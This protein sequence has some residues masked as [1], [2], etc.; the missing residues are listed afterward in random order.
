MGYGNSE[1][2]MVKGKEIKE[3]RRRASFR[4]EVSGQRVGHPPTDSGFMVMQ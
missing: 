3:M 2:V 4:P 1:C